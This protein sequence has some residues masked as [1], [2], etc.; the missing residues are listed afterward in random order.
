MTLTTPQCFA[1]RVSPAYCCGVFQFGGKDCGLWRTRRASADLSIFPAF[2]AGS[3]EKF[4]VWFTD[5]FA[6]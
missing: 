5:R 4:W 6:G 3:L 1:C 2:Q